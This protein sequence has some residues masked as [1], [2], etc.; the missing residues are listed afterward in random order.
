[1]NDN[2]IKKTKK[3]GVSFNYT[4]IIL[5]II[6]LASIYLRFHGLT[7]QSFWMDELQ[8]MLD[9][10]PGQ[11]WKYFFSSIKNLEGVHPPLF[12]IFERAFLSV[13]G[14][15]DW[16]GRTL[17]ALG[18]VASVYAIFFL[19]KEI[20]DKTLGLTAAT[21]MC[22]NYFSIY[23]SQQARMYT[24]V[25]LFTTLS[26]L[27]FIRLCKHLKIIDAAIF[28]IS[29]SCLIY[30]HYFGF[31]VII[32]EL[33]MAVFFLVQEK[34]KLKLFVILFI[35]ELIIVLLYIPWLPYLHTTGDIH[36][37]WIEP[38]KPKIFIE[39]FNAYF[40]NSILLSGIAI[41]FF[42]FFIISG[43]INISKFRNLKSN[44]AYLSF[45]FILV[46]IIISL[47]IPYIRSV[48]VI[49][50]L[51]PRFTMIILPSVIVAVAYGIE[52]I[53]VKKIRYSILSVYLLLSMY[54]LVIVHKYYRQVVIPQLREM[55]NYASN[56]QQYKIIGLNST[57]WFP[58]YVKQFGFKG[59]VLPG[60]KENYYSDSVL[61]RDISKSNLD[62]FNI[63]DTF[64]L[65]G[66]TE[67]AD[68]FSDKYM[69]KKKNKLPNTTF[70]ILKDTTFF[71]AWAQLYV[72][73]TKT[74]FKPAIY[75]F[76][77]AQNTND[78][79]DMIP[80]WS[81]NISSDPI[82][83]S[84]GQYDIIIASNGTPFKK[85]FPHNNLYVNNN[86][87]G[88]FTSGDAI[89]AHIFQFILNQDTAVT[90]KIDMDNDE[91]GNG[92]DRNTFI[93]GVYLAKEKD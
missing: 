44:P 19:G 17:S 28:V 13:F 79:S 45:I 80:I 2:V 15:N 8:T 63:A 20:K 14:Y 25:C 9:A 16:V 67:F 22:V 90:I 83:L 24:F 39:I 85:I 50:M 59:S 53:P 48:F 46:S 92:E 57:Y 58:Y 68:S 6:L 93:M 43:F 86:K 36:S 81:G 41:S 49:P 75:Y 74:V 54:Q 60:L 34:Q 52:I 89:G 73:K 87:I 26:Y 35:S 56:K 51:I 65:V 70:K 42:A 62:T 10:E 31:L 30:T 64:W 29:T 55:F 82:P 91:N 72:S 71:G 61:Q 84:R 37:F 33:V 7:K 78:V 32:S 18:G 47:G 40:D 76:K 21:L 77:Q 88:D 4:I 38:I 27:F 23:Y 12:F 5:L 1:M 66:L 3:D 69:I 11:T